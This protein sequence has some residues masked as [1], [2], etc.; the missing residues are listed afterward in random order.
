[1]LGEF[2]GFWLQLLQYYRL[3]IRIFI[4]IVFCSNVVNSWNKVPFLVCKL[5]AYTHLSIFKLI[6]VHTCW[7][8]ATF[9][10]CSSPGGYWGQLVH[11][12]RDYLLGTYL[13]TLKLLYCRTFFCIDPRPIFGLCIDIVEIGDLICMSRIWCAYPVSSVREF[14]SSELFHSRV[15]APTTTFPMSYE[16]FYGSLI[17]SDCGNSPNF[18]F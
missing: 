17:D 12:A 6:W 7:D 1:M 11:L 13:Q 2:S 3:D 16:K 10:Q 5:A 9:T 15:R 8:M 18:T 14:K 4:F